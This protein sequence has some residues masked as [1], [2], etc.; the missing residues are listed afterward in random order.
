M[1]D[2]KPTPPAR[3]PAQNKLNQFLKE[4]NILIG[5]DRPDIDFTGKGQLI[6]SAPRIVAVYVDEVKIKEAETNSKVN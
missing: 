2:R 5:T 3:E 1:D 6:V 4:N